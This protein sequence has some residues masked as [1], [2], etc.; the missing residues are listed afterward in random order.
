MSCLFVINCKKDD[1]K[2]KKPA[3]L[4]AFMIIPLLLGVCIK[5]NNAEGVPL[6]AL[7]TAM[8]KPEISIMSVFDNYRVNPE[9]KTGWGFASVIKMPAEQILFDTGGDSEILLFNMRKM[10]IHPRSIGKVVISHIHGDHIG[11]LAGFLDEN[12]NVTVFIPASFPDSVKRMI[13]G[14]GARFVE[15]S[16]AEKIS[17]F[18][19]TTGELAGPP[20]EQSL[21]ID[22]KKGLIVIT[23]CAHPGIVNIVEKAKN[24][25]KDSNV[26]LVAGGFH[27]PPVSVVKDL[28]GLGVQKVAPSHCTGDSVR[29]AFAEEYKEDFIKY[30][31]GRIIRIE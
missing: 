28:R 16:G 24:L 6:P 8:T 13:T 25:M 10:N 17:D 27:H 20:A 23:G 19:C 14:K 5:K 22:S 18:V 31:A 26:Y 11:G 12:N 21:V 3:L 15:I 7:R 1:R 30:G 2:M 4:L 9:L 29:E